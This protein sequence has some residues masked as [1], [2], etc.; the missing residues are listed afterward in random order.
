MSY[1][2]KHVVEYAFMRMVLGIMKLMPH[3]MALVVVWPLARLSY[4]FIGK[5]SREARRRMRTVLGSEVSEKDL[6][7]WA[8]LSWRNLV[9]NVVEIALAPHYGKRILGWYSEFKHDEM[10]ALTAQGKGYTVAVSHMGNWELTG[11][12]ARLSGI[13]LFVMMRGQS[14]PLV[15]QYLNDV[16]ASFDVGAIERH[17][18]V[19][20]AIMKRIRGGEVFTILPDIRAKTQ[21]TAIAVPYLGGTAYLTAGMAVFAKHTDTPIFPVVVRRIGWFR[22]SVVPHAPIYPDP[23]IERDA[24]VA[25]MTADVMAVFDRAIRETPGQYFWYNKRWVLDDRF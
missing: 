22:H 2:T 13:P 24:D 7:R 18:K 6:R 17:A 20:G 25:R 12:A 14:N 1:R 9:F 15:T 19:L 16:R 23:A 8:W 4:C 3:R 11:F 5:R 21:D 10:K